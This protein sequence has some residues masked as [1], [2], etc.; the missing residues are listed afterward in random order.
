MLIST[1]EK[2]TS[3][4]PITRAV[5]IMADVMDRLGLHSGTVFNY[6]QQRRQTKDYLKDLELLQYDILYGDQYV[7]NGKP[8]I[9]EVRLLLTLE[10]VFQ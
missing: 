5:L 4:R 7:Y 8:P 1:V 3:S 10:P 2:R 9:T 6:H